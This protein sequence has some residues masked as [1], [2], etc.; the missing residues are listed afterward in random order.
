MSVGSN[1][2][3]SQSSKV[4]VPSLLVNAICESPV[5]SSV[6][7]YD[8]VPVQ[9]S[10]VACSSSSD[11]SPRSIVSVCDPVVTQ[12]PNVPVLV[13]RD[14][15]VHSSV[16]VCENVKV[17]VSPVP[18]LVSD[19]VPLRPSASVCDN[20]SVPCIAGL[21]SGGTSVSCSDL[22]SDSV[23]VR[24]SSVSVS[25][26]APVSLHVP[27]HVELPASRAPPHVSCDAPVSPRFTFG[28]KVI[29][30]VTNPSA[31]ASCDTPV[32]S[33]V[34]VC[35]SVQVPV[36]VPVSSSFTSGDNV[37]VQPHNASVSVCDNVIIPASIPSVS[38]PDHVLLHELVHASGFPNYASCCF[39]VPSRL[40]IPRWR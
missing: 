35:D 2:C 37:K 8:N 9:V 36:L 1:F 29:S 5:S 10:R 20:M 40:N 17:Q 3:G 32:I 4:Q 12:V 31:R 11:A 18:V 39:P 6:F 22:V 23:D 25:G 38:V 27:V 14:A 34:P 7:V 28:D 16:S 15:P 21:D 13:S 19:D 33:S 26:D 24:A 30:Q